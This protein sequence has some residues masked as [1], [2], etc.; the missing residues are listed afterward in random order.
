L[1]RRGGGHGSLKNGVADFLAHFLYGGIF[2]IEGN[3]QLLFAAAGFLFAFD[4][5]VFLVNVPAGEQRGNE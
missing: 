1:S 2:A 5:P 4:E 3:G